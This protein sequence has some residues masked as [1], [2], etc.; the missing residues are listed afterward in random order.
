MYFLSLLSSIIIGVVLYIFSK[1]N[2][3]YEPYLLVVSYTD[4]EVENVIFETL[5]KHI[6]VYKIKSKTKTPASYE[7]TVEIRAKSDKS[8]IVNMLDAVGGILNVAM[9]SYNGEYAA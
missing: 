7:L 2:I 5:S 6:G 4:D 3:R 1:I 8:K 9:V